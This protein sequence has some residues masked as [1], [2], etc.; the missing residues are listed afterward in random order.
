MDWKRKQK[1]G[2]AESEGYARVCVSPQDGSTNTQ[3][4]IPFR[5]TY[6]TL[7]HLAAPR[8]SQKLE[9]KVESA[10]IVRKTVSRVSD[11]Q[12][13]QNGITGSQ[14]H[15]VSAAPEYSPSKIK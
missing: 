8:T 6:P 7:S 12:R 1:W 5:G 11:Y 13:T 14:G 15:S 10:L 2:S 3:T 9:M 4:A